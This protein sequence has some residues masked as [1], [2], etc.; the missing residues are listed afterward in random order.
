MKSNLVWI[1][2]LLFFVAK[3]CK[4]GLKC[5]PNFLYRSDLFLTI[6][7]KLY[8]NTM[9]D[10][11]GSIAN[12]F[13]IEELY[14]HFD[15]KAK[16]EF[17]VE[18][19]SIINALIEASLPKFLSILPQ[20]SLH[21][22][23]IKA[24]DIFSKYHYKHDTSKDWLSSLQSKNVLLKVGQ[25]LTQTD[26]ISSLALTCRKLYVD[27]HDKQFILQR[28]SDNEDTLMIDKNILDSITRL[29]RPHSMYYRYPIKLCIDLPEYNNMHWVL[30]NA[31]NRNDW[32]NMFS[33]VK[34]LRLQPHSYHLLEY[35]PSTLPNNCVIEQV[36]LNSLQQPP[37]YLD[38]VKW[39][40]IINTTI[41]RLTLEY[42]VNN[43]DSTQL[44][45]ILTK[46][47]HNAQELEIFQCTLLIDT[48]SYF[49]NLFHDHL[50][51]LMLDHDTFIKMSTEMQNHLV[52]NSQIKRLELD[53]C[54][55]VNN[56]NKH[57][58]KI[59]R[60][61]GLLNNVSTLKIYLTCLRRWQ[62]P[63]FP[64]TLLYYHNNNY[65][66]LYDLLNPSNDD[67]CLTSLSTILIS[68]QLVD[69]VQMQ[70]FTQEMQML[71]RCNCAPFPIKQLRINVCWTDYGAY[72]PDCEVKT[73]KADL[74]LTIHSNKEQAQAIEQMIEW[75]QEIDKY[76]GHAQDR[77]FQRQIIFNFVN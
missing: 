17:D 49:N 23:H 77:D 14:Q 61:H 5:S 27:T 33:N 25:Y 66:W 30:A 44:Q 64:S 70:E 2:L 20:A 65:G 47:P 6:Y 54:N 26:C 41:K 9:T 53:Q 15:N 45:R 21:Q 7:L 76:L 48:L 46:L 24:N 52:K 10:L 55:N 8:Q 43:D 1:C 73:P 63:V 40:S 71:N 50:Q 34:R 51:I 67:I 58:L 11:Q 35:F 12:V 57:N 42:Y 37:T 19:S 32:N 69:F 39:Q 4:N 18:I 72:K 29:R 75:L 60:D 59:L 68:T 36:H 22:L 31:D 56:H 38:N 16:Q 3:S 28:R 74:I 13:A 62:Q